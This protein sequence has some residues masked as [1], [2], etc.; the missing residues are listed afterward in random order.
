[1]SS[2]QNLE[3]FIRNTPAVKLTDLVPDI[4]RGI[5]VKLKLQNPQSRTKDGPVIRTISSV[6]KFGYLRRAAA[7]LEFSSGNIGIELART[8]MFYGRRFICV[9]NESTDN[10][11]FKIL[12]SY[13]TNIVSI[14]KLVTNVKDF[15]AV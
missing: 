8:C 10:Q 12:K 15:S 2:V 3:R 13:K 14:M 4:S 9:V 5:Y 6:S 1:M 7:A 11:N